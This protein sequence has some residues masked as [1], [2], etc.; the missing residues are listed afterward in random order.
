MHTTPSLHRAAATL[1]A[2]IVLFL[3]TAAPLPAPAAKI[4]AG[5]DHSV[6]VRSDG[7]LRGW[8]GD[9]S[10]QL[11]SARKLSSPLPVV[12]GGAT[13]ITTLASGLNYTVGLTQDGAVIGWGDNRA[14]Q[15]GEGTTTNLSVPVRAVGIT[16]AV[17]IAAGYITSYAV[18]ADGTV[19]GW[20]AGPF[21]NGSFGR[22]TL[23]VKVESL[24]GI[25]AVATGA[26][27]TLAL[28]SSGT[29]HAWGYNDSG[30]V[31]DGS[32]SPRTVPVPV[33]GLSGVTR[34]AA[35]F[36][37]S[38][39]LRGDGT[40]WAWGRNDSGQLG[41]GTLES[42]SS[43]TPVGGVT[44][45]IAI[46]AGGSQTLALKSDGTVWSWG[47]GAPT[48]QQV[49]G[50]TATAVATSGL[51]SL[52]LKGDGTVWAWGYN[53]FGELGD[54]TYNS[55]AV[56][57]MV[58]GLSGA[59]AVTAGDFHSAAV[60]A[61]GTVVAWGDNNAG[62]LGD[63]VPLSRPT[64]GVVQGFSAM[65][66]TAAGFNH[67][68]ALKQDGT[69]WGAGYN[70]S[71]QLGDG[72][73]STKSVAV[74]ASGVGGVVEVAAGDF[75]TLARR[76]DGTVWSWG[77]AEEGA[78]GR[79]GNG[80]TPAPIPGLA[81][82]TSIAAGG[83]SAVAVMADGTL[84]GWGSNFF[85]QF[86]PAAH[87]VT[88]PIPVPGFSN[89]TRAVVGY[90]FVVVLKADGTVWT[91]GENA[92][93]QL[94]DGTF[95]ARQ[96]P[97]QVSGLT[98]VVAIAA[99]GVHAVALKADGSVW[100][101]GY[102]G[103][104]ELGDGTVEDRNV[105][106]RVQ[107][108]SG[109]VAIAAN[110]TGSNYFF[111]NGGHTLALK[112]DGTVWSWGRSA[113][114]E[115]GD[116]TYVSRSTPQV[117]VAEDG[118]G[119]IEAGDWFLKLDPS[120]PATIPGANVPAM[121]VKS[122]FHGSGS[123]DAT[124]RYRGV[125]AGKSLNTY[126]LGLVPPKFFEL[127]DSTPGAKAK[128]RALGKAGETLILAQLTPQGWTN[129]EGQLIAYATGVG[130][131][132]SGAARILQGVDLGAIP[133][134]RF[135]IGYGQDVGAMLG[136]VTL[137]EVLA[138]QGASASAS[139]LPCV[140]AG[141]Y[142][143]GPSSSA[144]GSTATFTAAVVGLSPGGSVQF[145]NGAAPLGLAQAL[146]GSNPA[147]SRAALSIATLNPGVHSIGAFYS[148]DAQNRPAVTE[149]PKVHVVEAA[150]A[151]TRLTIAGPT[152]SEVG[153][154]VTFVA[155]ITG[156]RPGGV[157]QFR[158]GGAALGAPV[159][160][161]DGTAIFATTALGQGVHSITAF[162]AGDSANAPGTSPAL[163]HLVVHVLATSVSLSSDAN[164]AIAGNA[165][166]FTA[167]VSGSSPTGTV[168]FR[169]GSLTLGTVSLAAGR[170]SI[171]LS[172]LAAGTHAVSADYAGDG[173]NPRAS[174]NVLYQ[175]VGL[176][177]T[178]QVLTLTRLGAGS[179]SITS[180]PAGIAC[181][182][183]CS[184]D[185]PAD[186]SV[187]LTAAAGM[188]STFTGWGGACSGT[189]ACVV[190]MSGARSVIATFGV[191]CTGGDGDGDGI[192]DCV[193]AAEGR[194][195]AVKDNDV[196]NN[197]RLFAMQQYRDFLGREGDAGGVGF[198]AE[199]VASGARSR[200][201]GV[202]NFFQSPEF[203]QSGAPVAR[204]YFAYFLR[205]P[206]YAGLMYWMGQFRGGNALDTISNEF[207]KSPEFAGTY[208][209]L[210]NGQFVDRVY[211][212]VLGRPP[213]A[214]GLAFWTAQLDSGARNRG[215]VMTGFSES[216]EY[217]A[218]IANEI[219]VTMMYAGMLRRGAEPAGFAFWVDYLD[220]GNSGLA[221]IDGFL[222]SQEYR[223]RFLP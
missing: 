210:D 104:G 197:A 111:G 51:H 89:V 208:G 97:V 186:M 78:I 26:S 200:G 10:G 40:V 107:G 17:A 18:R 35:G 55:T 165:V 99:G 19:Y 184:V 177:I 98:Q 75:F 128:A 88:R 198:W 90:G 116:G 182:G 204:L 137:R 9:N 158:D 127:V 174:S 154:R 30:E 120:V 58:S 46:A 108:L 164:P 192:P 220:R 134:A 219:Y 67:T 1:G 74:Q 163:S 131:A 123:F 170:A 132:Q 172:N 63:G 60:R 36:S 66:A 122:Q 218:A 135:C 80:E 28:A 152:S 27:H 149:Y 215:Q 141:V 179:G 142:V 76:G 189:G 125:D 32:T 207:A 145:R 146:A 3:V 217:R 68:V 82:V 188:G 195:P 121:L 139:G 147:V 159:P 24:A 130:G 150:Q 85:Q 23:P 93:G 176:I 115:V 156:N 50:L 106:V 171:T 173:S 118:A 43:P 221:L 183:Q 117:V 29:V 59:V 162:Y 72:S 114:G 45:V 105:P 5:T 201:Q 41:D 91:M 144:A 57:V 209:A 167:A 143:D 54:G 161:V 44:G 119:S 213:E 6:V 20:G 21:G 203:Q 39:A 185:F 37:H 133:G 38:V 47:N 22:S 79:D 175:Q 7:T 15:L 86:G 62:E 96:S 196:F 81:G 12:V 202:E 48:P 112:A 214:A 136:A 212:N 194:N 193:E 181:P 199:Q 140:R 153:A 64:P 49:P 129:V 110:G 16:D 222:G 169:A 83:S 109:I 113:V 53:G 100:A 151:Q 157:V 42:R 190:T 65:T 211:R 33:P 13:R 216:D 191:A 138:L 166:T 71:G 14:G 102:N 31:G 61:D 25:T 155:S 95:T 4:S 69:V 126:V 77:S 223:N 160:I 8:G 92:L 56:P 168:T 124:V 206:D 101:W 148:G 11:G 2:S 87:P 34:I 73:R 52:A 84:R 178:R 205:I 180:N 94:G 187:T 103:H 70:F